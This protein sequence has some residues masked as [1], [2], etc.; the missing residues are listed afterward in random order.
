MMKKK[1]VPEN[2]GVYSPLIFVT[3]VTVWLRNTALA[4]ETPGIE[5]LQNQRY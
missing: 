3:A 2:E 4:I 1:N 5:R